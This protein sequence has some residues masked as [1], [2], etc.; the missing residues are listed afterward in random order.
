MIDTIASTRYLTLLRQRDAD[1]ETYTRRE[2][3]D[4]NMPIH[5]IRMQALDKN[6]SVSEFEAA[7]STDSVGCDRYG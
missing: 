3:N 7:D 6:I 1:H 5:M 4:L 2:E